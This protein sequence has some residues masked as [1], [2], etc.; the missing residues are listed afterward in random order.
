MDIVARE[1]AHIIPQFIGK[2]R[3]ASIGLE[4]FVVVDSTVNEHSCGGVRMFDNVSQDQLKA[5]ARGMTLKYGFSGMEQGGAKAGV[6]IDPEAPREL[7]QRLLSRFG[8]IISPLLRSN[9]YIPGPDMNVDHSDIDVMMGSAGVSVPAPR[10]NKGKKG[11]LY[12][13]IGVMV[14][15][16]AC[17]AVDMIDLEGVTVAIQGLGSVG[18]A[19]AFLL[20]RKKGC[21][22]VAA[23]TTHGAIYDRQ[24]LDVD[25]LVS[26]RERHGNAA[27]EYYRRAE[28]IPNDELLTLDVDVLAPCAGQYAITGENVA[29]VKARY[30]CPGANN[31]VTADAEVEFF[32]RGVVSIPYFAANCGGVLGNKIEV[33]GVGTD[34]VEEAIRRKNAT[35]LRQLITLSRERRQ[36]MMQ[37]AEEYAIRRFAATKVAAEERKAGSFV[38]SAGLKMFRNGLLPEKMLRL[39][40]PAYV[41]RTMLTDPPLA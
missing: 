13:A 30:V 25:E 24:G 20:A 19:L 23:S 1:A 38:K 17:G 12:T 36:P 16:E 10:R 11:G 14:A 7:K 6:V 29:D 34:Y 18:S 39:L 3:D 40:G 8:K 41:E 28:R 35:R 33:L 37:I 31:P 2:V 22:V 27:V 5:L 26:L 9:Y 15:I 21:K 4:G 32:R